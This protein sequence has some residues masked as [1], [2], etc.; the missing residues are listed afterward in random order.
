AIGNVFFNGGSAY[1]LA[2]E[3]Y[4]GEFSKLPVLTPDALYGYSAGVCRAY[5][6]KASA[7]KE[8]EQKDRK[9]AAAKM[10]RWTIP[11]TGSSP[12]PG[13]EVLIKAGSRLYA[14]LADRVVALP[15]PLQGTAKESNIAWQALT[16]GTP[17]S[18]V[19]ADDRLFVVTRE[20][21]ISC[22]GPEQPAPQTYAWKPVPLSSSPEWSTK[23][24]QIL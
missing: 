3:K 12:L 23:A 1:E 16:Q 19:A 9:G 22:F 20:G 6:F 24:R 18:L 7:I 10:T 4:L 17:A 2:T 8:A 13:T 21:R 5:D 14:G 15:L 11:Q